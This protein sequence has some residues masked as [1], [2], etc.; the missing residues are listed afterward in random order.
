[1]Q[2]KYNALILLF[3]SLFFL[4][5]GEDKAPTPPDDNGTD[6]TQ[7][8]ASYTRNFELIANYNNDECFNKLF[9]SVSFITC[10]IISVPTVSF[11]EPPP[12]TAAVLKNIEDKTFFLSG[13]EVIGEVLHLNHEEKIDSKLYND[14]L[15]Q[16]DQDAIKYINDLIGYTI[17]NTAGDNV[18]LDDFIYDQHIEF[19]NYDS[20]FRDTHVVKTESSISRTY[21]VIP[22]YNNDACFTT[23]FTDQDFLSCTFIAINSIRIPPVDEEDSVKLLSGREMLAQTIEGSLDPTTLTDKEL[24]E[25]AKDAFE[26]HGLF[27]QTFKDLGYEVITNAENFDLY[28]VLVNQTEE[29]RLYREE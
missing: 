29:Y 28:E 22:N 17:M 19:T 2:K 3:I 14:A 6:D 7:T 4:S 20:Q 26:N 10:S 25:L 13:R 21:D 27:L 9:D 15:P 5:C 8:V 12:E 11:E 1:M 24:Y 23:T 16:Y 18:P